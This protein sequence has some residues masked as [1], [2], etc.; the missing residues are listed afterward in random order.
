IERREAWRARSAACA[1]ATTAATGRGFVGRRRRRRLIPA[2]EDE[3]A[4][5]ADVEH[6]LLPVVAS[7]F[8]VHERGVVRRLLRVVHD[9]TGEMIEQDRLPPG[10]LE[11][12]FGRCRIALRRARAGAAAL[13][14]RERGCGADGDGDA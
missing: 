4:P 11:R 7:D 9:L 1:T 12:K 10:R 3:T 5:V 6:R 14:L 8:P 2:A 13:A